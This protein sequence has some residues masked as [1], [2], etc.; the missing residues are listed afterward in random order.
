M[1]EDELIIAL[2]K[3]V[4]EEVFGYEDVDSP[5]RVHA[6]RF[7]AMMKAYEEAKFQKENGEAIKEWNIIAK[8]L[9]I[10]E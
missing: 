3:A 4:D 10:D 9:G 6:R 7:I 1:S 8:G 5:N 2:A